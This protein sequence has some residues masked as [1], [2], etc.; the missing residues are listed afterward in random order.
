MKSIL[1]LAGLAVTHA[2]APAFDVVSIKLSPPDAGSTVSSRGGPGTRTPG[3]WTCQ[4]MSL[5]NIVWIAFNLRSQ[6]LV[7]PEWMNEPRFNITAKI[8]EGAPRE[9]YYLMFQSMLARA[10][11]P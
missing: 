8:P 3:V 5:H 4:N 11:R 2:Q 10:S 9:H 1:M 7:A 6:Q